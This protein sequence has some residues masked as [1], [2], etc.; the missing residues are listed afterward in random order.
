MIRTLSSYFVMSL[1]IT[2]HS[3]KVQYITTC[4]RTV[5][6]TSHL[7]LAVVHHSIQLGAV[8]DVHTAS[9]LIKRLMS[10][11]FTNKKMVRPP[12]KVMRRLITV[13]EEFLKV[14]EDSELHNKIV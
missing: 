6:L 1:F 4:T 3:L 10:L 12:S 13:G 7:Y 2:H 9:S 11:L 8:R 14:M 5:H